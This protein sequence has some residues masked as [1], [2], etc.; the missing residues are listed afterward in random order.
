MNEK[1]I[2][3]HEL[4]ENQ[5]K[6]FDLEQFVINSFSFKILF[7]FFSRENHRLK[8]SIHLLKQQN[9]RFTRDDST[10]Q[11]ESR[12]TKTFPSTNQKSILFD[13]KKEFFFYLRKKF[14]TNQ[15]L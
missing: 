11:I 4:R 3:Q 13:R 12:Q 15:I 2:L 10:I 14:F 5:E 9:Q 6:Y 8:E 7:F 1:K